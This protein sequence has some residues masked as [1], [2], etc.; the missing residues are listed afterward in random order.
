[1]TSLQ[2]L[3]LQLPPGTLG[4]NIQQ[5]A[6][7][8]CLVVSKT[9]DTSPFRVGDTVLSLNGTPFNLY[10]QGE[11]VNTIRASAQSGTRTVVVR[12]RHT[13]TAS[14]PT[15]AHV[16]VA[17]PKPKTKPA[18]MSLAVSGSKNTRV[19]QNIQRFESGAKSATSTGIAIETEAQK[20]FREMK[21]T[22]A[23]GQRQKE[24]EYRRARD[25][26]ER[27]EKETSARA[28]QVEAE[29]LE[30]EQQRAKHGK[31]WAEKEKATTSTTAP[32]AAPKIGEKAEEYHRARGEAER[33]EKE[34]LARA[35]QVETELLE[36]EQ[37]RANHGKAWAKKEKA[38]TSTTAPVAAPK[39][40]NG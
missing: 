16:R 19:S 5:A 35:K 2:V 4:V 29:L 21:E 25:E 28:K 7:G 27:S 3:R 8:T 20:K 22:R 6:D 23:A 34:I 10:K 32:A 11:W 9:K 26:A 18:S 14:T 33:S 36:L 13:I 40:A 31:A 12:R 39:T 30:L 1:M 38:T 37:Q 15:A 17:S 24:E